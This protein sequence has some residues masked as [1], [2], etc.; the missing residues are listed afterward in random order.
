MNDTTITRNNKKLYHVQSVTDWHDEP[1]DIFVF[2]ELEPN[3][4]E[5]T[6]LFKDDLG[7]FRDNNPELKDLVNNANIYTVYAVEQ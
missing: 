4:K 1:Y 3:Q 7:Y 2:S 5:L 6:E